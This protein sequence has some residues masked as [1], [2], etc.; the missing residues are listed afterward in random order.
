MILSQIGEISEAHELF[1]LEAE[2]AIASEL[3]DLI[4]YY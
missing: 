1:V 4:Y 3:P 2:E